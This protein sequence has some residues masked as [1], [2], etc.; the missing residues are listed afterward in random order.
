MPQQR[1]PAR[2][3]LGKSGEERP[4]SAQGSRIR[5]YVSGFRGCSL[6][7][8]GQ[9]LG[10]RFKGLGSKCLW[11]ASTNIDHSLLYISAIGENNLERNVNAA[12][13]PNPT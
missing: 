1:L 11:H 2:H 6:E 3:P 9:A 4:F 12:D 10:F 8:T 13:F 5:L 7:L